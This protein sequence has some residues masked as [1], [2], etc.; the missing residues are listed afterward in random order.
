MYAGCA[1]PGTSSSGETASTGTADEDT[2]G[3]SATTTGGSTTLGTTGSEPDSPVWPDGP[4]DIVPWGDVVFTRS[5]DGRSVLMTVNRD[6]SGLGPIYDG[7]GYA[8][9]SADGSL[10]MWRDV[11]AL[12]VL[13]QDGAAAEQ[14]PAIV[15]PTWGPTGAMLAGF[16]AGTLVA[17]DE[18]DGSPL[19]ELAGLR[20]PRALTW[21]PE[22]TAIAFQDNEFVFVV[23]L[24]TGA[25][26]LVATSAQSVQLAW[27]ADQSQIAMG[28]EGWIV[29]VDLELLTSTQLFE[30]VGYSDPKGPFVSW[31][32]TQEWIAWV[33]DDGNGR[34]GLGRPDGTL[35]GP[36]PTGLDFYEGT[37][38]WTHDGSWVAFVSSESGHGCFEVWGCLGVSFL[39][40]TAHEDLVYLP[41]V[42]EIEWSSSRPEALV[43]GPRIIE[44]ELTASR[45]RLYDIESRESLDLS[46]LDSTDP[47]ADQGAT[48]RVTSG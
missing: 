40:P 42:G 25:S 46:D 37:P 35:T 26:E 28:S 24:S 44:N 27:A 33:S 11:D 20:S 36:H 18:S 43:A 10:L 47:R 7:G 31:S 15:E 41:A 48:W 23:D 30:V 1:S 21:S 2:A 14:R 19:V 8:D 3:T 34:G 6:G 17:T 22:G 4:L 45:V 13:A 29:L 16:D 9:V 39:Q 32:P 12:F 5:Y 38:R